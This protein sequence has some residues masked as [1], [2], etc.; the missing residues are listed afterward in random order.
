MMSTTN[1]TTAADDVC[2]VL[3]ALDAATRD[4]R[5]VH[6]RDIAGITG[7]ELVK[8]RGICFGLCRNGL[9]TASE[10]ETVAEG[11]L[12]RMRRM[13]IAAEGQRALQ[14]MQGGH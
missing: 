13:I 9:A 11:D 7:L 2:R 6:E 14:Q 5:R 12:N 10:P 4:G 1:T 8:V 3:E